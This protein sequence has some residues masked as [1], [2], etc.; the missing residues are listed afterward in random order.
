M[1]S[2]EAKLVVGARSALFLPFSDLGLIIV[3][4]EH[5]HAYKQ[6]DQTIYQARDMA[7][8]RAHIHRCPIILASATPSLESWV[9]AG[10]TGENPRY[11]HIGLPNRINGA[12]LP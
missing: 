8:V 10:K 9:N 1:L 3:D 4:E 2:G 7:V 5:D 12:A 11:Q 6:E